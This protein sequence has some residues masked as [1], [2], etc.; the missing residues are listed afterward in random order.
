[1]SRTETN[2]RYLDQMTARYGPESWQVELLSLY[3]YEVCRN[4]Y[5]GV[6]CLTETWEGRPA[7]SIIERTDERSPVT[8]GDATTSGQIS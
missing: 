4:V 7:V 5:P 1:M 6:Y 2:A 3:H 8:M